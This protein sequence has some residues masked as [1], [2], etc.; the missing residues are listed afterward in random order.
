MLNQE[1]SIN[2]FRNFFGTK[3][4]KSEFPEL[5]SRTFYCKNQL[6]WDWLQFID[7][8]NTS[9]SEVWQLNVEK[10][11]LLSINLCAIKKKLVFDFMIIFLLLNV[12][13]IRMIRLFVLTLSK[14][15]LNLIIF[16]TKSLK[17]PKTCAIKV[18]TTKMINCQIILKF[19]LFLSPFVYDPQRFNLCHIFSEKKSTFS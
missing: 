7:R 5:S 6:E 15:S 13:N 18:F 3:H 16:P 11:R 4:R 14:I 19:Q 10:F 17:I 12:W 8:V 9:Y 2:Y 1:T